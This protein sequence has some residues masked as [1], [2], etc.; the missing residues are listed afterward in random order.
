MYG[1]K[2]KEFYSNFK[3]NFRFLKNSIILISKVDSQVDKLCAVL[4]EVQIFLD[5]LG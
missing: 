1:C 4:G 3:R 2:I 5:D